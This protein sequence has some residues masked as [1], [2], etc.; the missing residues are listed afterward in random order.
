MSSNNKGREAPKKH[1]DTTYLKGETLPNCQVYRVKVTTCFLQAGVHAL[2]L[3]DP[4]H[5]S[6]L[7]PFILEEEQAMIE[8]EIAGKRSQL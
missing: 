5:M 4:R 6:D 1:N 2:W 7:I 8:N 3:I